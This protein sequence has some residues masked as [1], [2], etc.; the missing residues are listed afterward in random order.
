MTGAVLKGVTSSVL[1]HHIRRTDWLAISRFLGSYI[2]VDSNSHTSTPTL[3]SL[4]LLQ[5]PRRPLEPSWQLLP[6]EELPLCRIHT[7]QTMSR[8]ASDPKALV[9]ITYTLTAAIAIGRWCRSL[10]PS[11]SSHPVQLA[12]HTAHYTTQ[13]QIAS[14]SKRV[15]HTSTFG[16][17]GPCCTA[18]CL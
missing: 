1:V 5:T 9:T 4:N 17:K 15:G 11:A 7:P 3:H 10:N 18:F 8:P 13:A 6:I 12:L 14:D 16:P 2:F